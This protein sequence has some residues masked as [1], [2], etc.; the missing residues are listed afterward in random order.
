MAEVAQLSESQ[1]RLANLVDSLIDHL[2]KVRDAESPELSQEEARA[3]LRAAADLKWEIVVGWYRDESISLSRA[4]E[5]LDTSRWEL[6]ARF[7][8]NDI[9]LRVG[10]Q[11]FDELRREVGE[12]DKVLGDAELS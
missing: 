12:V 1:A 11:T 7:R 6:E 3:G 2:E 8:E 5:L 4:A 9:P 10:P